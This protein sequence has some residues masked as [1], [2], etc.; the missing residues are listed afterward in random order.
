MKLIANVIAMHV[1]REGIFC[2]LIPIVQ[3]FVDLFQSFNPAKPSRI[4]GTLRDL[5][6]KM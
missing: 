4:H 6:S 5:K 1:D 3:F 2:A